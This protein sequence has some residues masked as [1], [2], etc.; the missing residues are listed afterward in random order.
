MPLPILVQ[1][2]EE[3]WDG[4]GHA[5][6]GA[7]ERDRLQ[8]E[9]EQAI[10]QHFQEVRTTQAQMQV[11]EQGLLFQAKEAFDIAQFSFRHGAASGP[12]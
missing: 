6:T 11:F 10:T 5:S 9:L 4:D 1:S 3:T 8:Q 2:L 12:S 7:S